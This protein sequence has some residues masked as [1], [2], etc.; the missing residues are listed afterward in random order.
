MKLKKE[1]ATNGAWPDGVI[2]RYLNVGGATVDLHRKRYTTQW[3]YRGAP[4][5]ADTPYEVEGY[6]WRCLGCDAY[7]REGDTYN[8]PGYRDLSKTRDAAQ[9]HAERRRAIPRPVDIS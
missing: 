8:D 9:E 2:I 4:Y 3:S 1:T 5:A 6:N 7:G